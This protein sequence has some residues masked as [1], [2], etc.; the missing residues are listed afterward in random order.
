MALSSAALLGVTSASNCLSSP[1]SRAIPGPFELLRIATASLPEPSRR[2][3][4]SCSASI[5]PAPNTTRITAKNSRT[6]PKIATGPS[7]LR[8]PIMPLHLDVRDD[9]HGDHV[10]AE[11]DDGGRN[12][13]RENRNVHHLG[14]IVGLYR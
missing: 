12:Q 10:D 14:I 2:W 6:P 3:K 9:A 13:L 4:N 8:N 11:Q 1:S 5:A 7:P